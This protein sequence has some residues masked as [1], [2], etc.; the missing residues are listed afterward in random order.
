MKIRN[1]FVSNSSSS[2]YLICGWNIHLE[3]EKDKIIEIFKKLGIDYEEIDNIYEYIYD[4]T[5][6]SLITIKDNC[7]YIGKLLSFFD[8]CDWS[9][10]TFLL[11]D[12]IKNDLNKIKEE[13]DIDEPIKLFLFRQQC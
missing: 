8:D 7:L 11:E 2:S 9:D 12:L 5:Y 1:G 6:N 13:F 10:D 4:E 3:D